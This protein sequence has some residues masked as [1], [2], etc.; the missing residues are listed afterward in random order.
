[1]IEIKIAIVAWV[2]SNILIDEGMIFEKWWL[3]LNKLPNWLSKPLGACEYCL[4]GQIA[5]WYYIVKYV[6]CGA[7]I[8]F[9][10]HIVAISVVIF[11]VHLINIINGIKRA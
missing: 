2:F 8:G 1:M 11:F 9:I 7:Y 3:V 4:A 10:Q 5:L 6:Y